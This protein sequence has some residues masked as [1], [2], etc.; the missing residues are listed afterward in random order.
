MWFG[1]SRLQDDFPKAWQKIGPRL[2]FGFEGFPKIS[3]LRHNFSICGL[4]SRA[5]RLTQII[6]QGLLKFIHL[7]K[8]GRASTQG[9]PL[10]LSFPI[11]AKRRIKRN[12]KHNPTESCVTNRIEPGMRQKINASHRAANWKI[13]SHMASS[14]FTHNQNRI[15]PQRGF[16][17]RRWGGLGTRS[18]VFI[19]VCVYIYIYI[20]Y[21]HIYDNIWPMRRRRRPANANA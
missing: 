12:R 19:Y 18:T 15:E 4:G 13:E 10:H 11:M 14:H 1:V 21:I 9:L 5:S 17:A 2:W 20:H 7:C 3:R 8:L 6:V 16:H